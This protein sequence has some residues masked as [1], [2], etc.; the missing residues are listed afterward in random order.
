MD[1]LISLFTDF[2]RKFVSLITSLVVQPGRVLQEIIRRGKRFA[3]PFRIYSYVVS[4]CVLLVVIINTTEEGFFYETT[5]PRIPVFWENFGKSQKDFMIT[6]VP[7]LGFIEVILLFSLFTW[8]IFRRP[9]ATLL[10]HL[11]YNT[12]VISLVGIYFGFVTILFTVLHQYYAW[13]E[14]AW[15]LRIAFIVIPILLVLNTF[16]AFHHPWY[17]ILL[18]G[19]PII[20][21]SG[22]IIMRIFFL[23][24]FNERLHSFV[25]YW[26]HER[27]PVVPS[28]TAAS[29]PLSG[30]DLKFHS[31]VVESEGFFLGMAGVQGDPPVMLR[32][33]LLGEVEVIRDVIPSP[34]EELFGA[35][36]LPHQGEGHYIFLTGKDYDND[37]CLR[38]VKVSYV[39]PHYTTSVTTLD[40]LRGASVMRRQGKEMVFSFYDGI[41]NEPFLLMVDSTFRVTNR[42]RLTPFSNWHIS[43]FHVQGDSLMLVFRQENANQSLS[44]IMIANAVLSDSA[45]TVVNTS[46]FYDNPYSDRVNIIA[47]RTGVPKLSRG[48]LATTRDSG[49][50]LL[51]YRLFTEKSFA[52]RIASINKTSLRLNWTHDF[53]LPYDMVS[54][55]DIVVKDGTIFIAGRAYELVTGDFMKQ[56]YFHPFILRLEES[57]GEKISLEV[58]EQSY[59]VNA[60]ETS[61]MAHSSRLF[62]ESN[63]IILFHYYGGILHRTE[64]SLSRESGKITMFAGN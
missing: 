20:G 22:L 32:A 17:G 57:K 25:V 33:N 37:P 46:L 14:N 26:P 5:N 44:R 56:P 35:F 1:D 54:Y 24:D 27:H 11:K 12:Y 31:G 29:I 13:V 10:H 9:A 21:V 40:S 53:T 49:T 6:M 42:F 41:K 28:R 38:Q 3:S 43:D 7:V 8:L 58:L 60:I 51:A 36:D 64:V 62:F 30:P 4:V 59:P 23:G 18:R 19:I 16:R 34:Q 15:T 39:R 48:Y 2:E 63:R 45:I 61:L 52:L 47:T 55:D 50:C